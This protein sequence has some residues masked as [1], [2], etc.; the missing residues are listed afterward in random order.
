MARR[1]VD[2]DGLLKAYP[3]LFRNRDQIYRRCRRRKQPLPHRKDG[4]RYL[5]DLDLVPLWWDRLDGKD[6]DG[7][8]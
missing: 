2:M 1:I 8:G 5:F 6:L 4:N 7:I 3:D